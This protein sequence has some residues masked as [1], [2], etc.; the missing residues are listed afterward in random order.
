MSF[1]SRCHLPP[2]R[3]V[4]TFTV[5]SPRLSIFSPPGP[6]YRCPFTEPFD[7][8][9]SIFGQSSA[10]TTDSHVP[11]STVISRYRPR[12]PSV[13][14][15]LLSMDMLPIVTAFRSTSSGPHSPSLELSLGRSSPSLKMS[16]CGAFISRRWYTTSFWYTEQAGKFTERQ[17]FTSGIDFGEFC[18]QGSICCK[19]SNCS[20]FPSQQSKESDPLR[21]KV[22]E[23]SRK[24]SLSS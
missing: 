12:S 17:P 22:S 16:Y 13:A 8:F 20:C 3:L 15:G 14:T 21:C 6:T 5:S 11:E 18:A 24:A 2:C 19:A 9:K 4:R 7:G 10:F 1:G 23:T